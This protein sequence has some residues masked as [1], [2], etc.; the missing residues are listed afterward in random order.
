MSPRKILWGESS[1]IPPDVRGG[2]TKKNVERRISSG[3][4]QAFGAEEEKTLVC[5]SEEIQPCPVVSQWPCREAVGLSVVCALAYPTSRAVCLFCIG[6]SLSLLVPPSFPSGEK[7]FGLFIFCCLCVPTW[8]E[9]TFRET[10]VFGISV[11]F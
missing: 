6:H 10:T 3:Y 4:P 11:G 8:E 7:V 9:I 5:D 1:R 2:G